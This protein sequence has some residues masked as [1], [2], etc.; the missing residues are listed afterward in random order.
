[1]IFIADLHDTQDPTFRG[2]KPVN[3]RK[4]LTHA[5]VPMNPKFLATSIK[6]LPLAWFNLETMVSAGC[7]TI[8]QNTPAGREKWLLNYVSTTRRMHPRYHSTCDFF[9]NISPLENN[10]AQQS[11]R[12]RNIKYNICRIIT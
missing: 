4:N 5:Y 3:W 1:M 2:K 8:A 6:L 12:N 7:E 11:L 10:C 9:L